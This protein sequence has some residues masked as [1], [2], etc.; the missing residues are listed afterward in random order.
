VL[1]KIDKIVLLYIQNVRDRKHCRQI[2]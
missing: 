1:P 2:H